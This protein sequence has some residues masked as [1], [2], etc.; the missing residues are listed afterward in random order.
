MF[1]YVN[2]YGI[3]QAVSDIELKIDKTKTIKTNSFDHMNRNDIVGKKL[4]IGLPKETKDL[5]VAVICN[6]GG[7]C[8]IATYAEAL[9][10][11]MKSKVKEVRIFSELSSPDSI[12]CWKR[13]ES[14]A[15]CINLIKEWNPD[16]VHIQHEFGI[17]PKATHF[18]KMLEMLGDIPYAITLHSV[19]EHL[20]KTICSAYIKN[21]IVHSEHGKQALLKLGHINNIYVVDH[22]CPVYENIE[23]L[24]NIF[25]NDY[26]VIQF[27]FG[28][29]YKGVD[30][31]IDAINILQK[32]DPKFK[33][34]FYCY[35]CSENPVTRYVHDAYYYSIKNK[36]DE[37][38]LSENITVLRGFAS[39]KIIANF[40]RTARLAIFP[41]KTD[42]S[43]IVY[44][45]SGAIRHAMANGVP[46][47]ASES[48]MFDDLDGVLPRTV[49]AES[50][51]SEIDKIFSDGEYRKSLVQKNLEFVKN[52]SWS[53]AA[54]QHLIVYRQ[55]VDSFHENS[56]F[57]ELV[58]E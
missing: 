41:Y 25:Q 49:D 1:V 9:I 18:L 16:I 45:A 17:F 22:G 32:N 3:I 11:E 6:W 7:Q 33:N 26:A 21:I 40:L 24:W 56:L 50:L 35:L 15:S 53:I 55:V 42:P 29:S 5:K 48:H 27:G 8:G 30:M 28:F 57:L 39:E 37:L 13:G 20:D 19:Y 58:H 46:T 44:G 14:M 54:E 34:I 12:Q 52:H 2:E 43:N 31:A 23:E 4:R 36:V 10:S 51:A 38:N 47:I